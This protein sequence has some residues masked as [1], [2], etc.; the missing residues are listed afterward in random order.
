MSFLF[1][2]SVFVVNAMHAVVTEG[3][4]A[5]GLTALLILLFLG[6]W[7]STIVV[8]TVDSARRP[9]LHHSADR[10]GLLAQSD[11]ARRAGA[12]GRYPGRRR[13]GDHREYP[14][15]HGDGQVDQSTPCWTARNRS[16]CRRSCRCCRSA[17]CFCRCCCSPVPRN[18]CS[19]RWRW[20]SCLPWSLRTCWRARWCRSWRAICSPEDRTGDGCE[21]LADWHA[22]FEAGFERLRQRYLSALRWTLH[23]RGRPC[24][25]CS[26]SWWSASAGAAWFVGWDF[27]PAVDAG[28][29]RLH[30]NAPIGTRIEAYR[31]DLHGSRGRDPQAH[32]AARPG[33]HHRQHRHSAVD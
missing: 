29:I 17:W 27:F 4:I 25:C 8:V 21:R 12:G 1:D 24:S 20:R 5:A 6:S 3:L 11:D 33:R 18:I 26:R 28:Q 9:G 15:P 30:V 14:S 16:S 7:R 32:H 10:A 13:H 2:Q 19:R 22:R 31:R 23:Q